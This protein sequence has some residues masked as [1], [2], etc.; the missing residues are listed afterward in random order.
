MYIIGQNYVLKWDS[1][2]DGE[3]LV[4]DTWNSPQNAN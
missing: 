4:P 3:T 1:D 2:E